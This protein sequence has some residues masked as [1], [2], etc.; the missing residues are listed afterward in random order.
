MSGTGT[1]A[2]GG[3]GGD[4]SNGGVGGKGGDADLNASANGNGLG[5]R[6]RW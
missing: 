4:G 1:G 5:H 2:T 6:D 3:D